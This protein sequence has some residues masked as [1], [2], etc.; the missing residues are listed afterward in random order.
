ML[1]ET[2]KVQE[3]YSLKYRGYVAMYVIRK[4]LLAVKSHNLLQKLYK[5]ITIKNY[6]DRQLRP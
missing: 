2:R 3:L 4:E 5:K 6:H 1:K